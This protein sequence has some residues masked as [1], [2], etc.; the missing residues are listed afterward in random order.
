MH[1]RLNPEACR[2]SPLKDYIRGRGTEEIPMA[3]RRHATRGEIQVQ[4]TTWASDAYVKLPCI[5]FNICTQNKMERLNA[6]FNKDVYLTRTF[7]YLSLYKLCHKSRGPSYIG[8]H[9]GPGA[10]PLLACARR[11][12]WE[13]QAQMRSERRGGS[14]AHMSHKA[15]KSVDELCNLTDPQATL[16][17]GR[18][19]CRHCSSTRTKIRSNK[20]ARNTKRKALEI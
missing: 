16:H 1:S 9:T 11:S 18:W 6:C 3:P 13:G 5:H 7:Y 10:V 14:A 2:P 17:F 4:C 8:K 19:R 15:N 20:K 12:H